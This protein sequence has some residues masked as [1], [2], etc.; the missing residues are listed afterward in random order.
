MNME[1]KSFWSSVISAY[2]IDVNNINTEIL[3]KIISD[4]QNGDQI[5]R[6][7]IKLACEA[8]SYSDAISEGVYSVKL[9]L[10]SVITPN[11]FSSDQING[12]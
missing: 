1:E 2:Q 4:A 5:A 6:K 3:D 10:I 11:N 7:A 12:N 8:L 9:S